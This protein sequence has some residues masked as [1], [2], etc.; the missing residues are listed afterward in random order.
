VGR[1]LEEGFVEGVF[2]TGGG[3]SVQALLFYS[4]IMV[5]I[6]AVMKRE[7][8]LTIHPSWEKCN[9]LYESANMQREGGIR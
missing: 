8:S 1:P 6:G 3:N 9:E 7:V 5:R 4:C 2:K